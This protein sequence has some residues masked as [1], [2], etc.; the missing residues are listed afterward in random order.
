MKVK[1][2]NQAYRRKYKKLKGHKN[3]QFH[4]EFKEIKTRVKE[5]EMIVIFYNFNVNLKFKLCQPCQTTNVILTSIYITT[6]S[7]MTNNYCH[8][9]KHY[10]Y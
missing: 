1:I 3:R 9:D 10:Q 8:I 4:K 2:S 7:N 6:L 5:N